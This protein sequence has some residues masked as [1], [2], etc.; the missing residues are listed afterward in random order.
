MI[1]LAIFASCSKRTARISQTRSPLR[2][3]LQ[4]SKSIPASASSA[5]T[6]PTSSAVSTSSAV[7]VLKA[8]PV[9]LPML[10]RHVSRLEAVVGKSHGND[11][12]PRP[13]EARR[14]SKR[15]RSERR[16]AS[17]HSVGASA[18]H[19]ERASCGG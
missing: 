16:G 14:R 19:Q 10:Q 7:P 18:Q 11:F 15:R 9:G 12:G 5:A 2:R 4:T 17:T 1:T 6:L 13:V 3:R 8:Q